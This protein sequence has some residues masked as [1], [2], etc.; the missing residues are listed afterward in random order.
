MPLLYHYYT[1]A[2]PLLYR[3]FTYHY[4]TIS[5]PYYTIDVNRPLQDPTL[6]FEDETFDFVVNA[7]SWR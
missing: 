7:D 5:I 1:I 6:N 3:Y 2:V 4:Y